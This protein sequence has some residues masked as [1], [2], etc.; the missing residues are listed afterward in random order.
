MAVLPAIGIQ[1]YNEFD[2]RRSRERDIR[3]Q[4]IQVTK[5][6]GEEMGELREG[7]RQLLLVLGQL[8]VA[9]KDRRAECSQLFSSLK[10]R[11][12]NYSVMGAADV[13][14]NVFCASRPFS[15]WTVADQ[16]FFMR[17]LA[18]DG[19]AV[20]NYFVDSE[21]GEKR[22]DIAHRFYD[23]K[24]Q[25]AG[26]VFVGLDLAWLSDHLKER[27]LSPT[28]SILIADRE[29]NIIARLPNPEKLVGKNMRSGHAQIM[30]GNK[31]AGKRRS[32]STG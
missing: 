5:Q 30:D 17:A 24:N 22:I 12:P 11:F 6:F 21:S 7:A 31:A 4:V 26:V 1:A 27:G 25:V 18:R 8:P 10:T 9:Q 3:E 20:G 23:D 13:E 2:L 15:N 14:G 29:G 28:A 19:T 16:P 32:A